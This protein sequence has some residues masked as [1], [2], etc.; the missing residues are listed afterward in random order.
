MALSSL[1][2]IIL[3]TTV[4][5]SGTSVDTGGGFSIDCPCIDVSSVFIPASNCIV[6]N[7]DDE[8]G[9]F[10]YKSSTDDKSSCIPVTYGSSSCMQHDMSRNPLCLVDNY[11]ISN[12]D[13]VLLPEFCRES[14]CYVDSTLCRDSS[15]SFMRTDIFRD[16]LEAN[17]LYYSYSTCNSTDYYTDHD[18]AT[19]LS[20]KGKFISVVVPDMLSPSHY[21]E[22]FDNDEADGDGDG[23]S[24]VLYENDTVPWKGWV[25]EYLNDVLDMSDIGGFNYTYRSKYSSIVKNSSFWTASLSFNI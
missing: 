17:S 20:T 8:S 25:I 5:S 21:K 18:F 11:N 22:A 9:L 10:L 3:I 4:I 2:T 13:A 24:L 6:E 1:L 23:L 19:T 16:L 12:Q 14:W 7:T 15:E